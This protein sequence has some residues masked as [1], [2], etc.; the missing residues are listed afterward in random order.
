MNRTL[1]KLYDNFKN[2][3][4]HKVKFNKQLHKE[5]ENIHNLFTNENFE[6]IKKI[7]YSQFLEESYI[8][9]KYYNNLFNSIEGFNKNKIAELNP[10]LIPILN[11]QD[12]KENIKLIKQKGVLYT[13]G[14]TS[15]TTGSPLTIYRTKDSILKENAYVWWYRIKNGLNPG[16]PMVSIRGD[17]NNHEKIFHDKYS[18]ILHISS[19]ALN[20]N[21]IEEV[22][23]TIYN[24]KPKA[25]AGYPSSI[26]TLINI[27]NSKNLK[28]N[29][30]KIFTSS[31]TLFPFQ[32]KNIEKSLKASIFD[33]YGNSE[34]TIA[35]YKENEKYYEPPLYGYNYYFK[36]YILTNSLINQGFPLINYNVDDV[37]I[38]NNEYDKEKKSII[39]DKIEGRNSNFIIIYDGSKIGTAALSLIFKDIDIVYSQIIFKKMGEFDI[40]VVPGKSFSDKSLNKLKQDIELKL[41]KENQISLKI[42]NESEL[43]KNKSGKYSFIIK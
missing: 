10:R 25:I 14:Y 26:N 2:Y 11:R 9:S 15:G 38:T 5:I 7:R 3:I 37:I 33:W 32:I 36:D 6:V 40:N 35:L 29:V 21:S 12:V 42:I 20:H 30:S 13:K 39:I 22:Y 34:R 8:K 19:F 27:F 1:P 23:N 31:E 24:F 43:I 4:T 16:D 41:G 28:F 18:N 17:L